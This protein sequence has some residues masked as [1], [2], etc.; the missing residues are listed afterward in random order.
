VSGF[1]GLGARL[2]NACNH[3]GCVR[4]ELSDLLR[5]AAAE[6]WPRPRPVPAPPATRLSLSGCGACACPLRSYF[7]GPAFAPFLRLLLPHFQHKH[8]LCAIW[9][10]Y[11][12]PKGPAHQL[13]PRSTNPSTLARPFLMPGVAK[14]RSPWNLSN[15]PY[16]C[17]LLSFLPGL[18][19]IPEY[20]VRLQGCLVQPAYPGAAEPGAGPSPASAGLLPAPRAPRALGPPCFA[21][22]PWC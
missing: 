21:F 16:R 3:Q 10:R 4:L 8:L 7:P 1:H 12:A 13:R 14:S 20:A 15:E 6:P 5:A 17:H 22:A 19:A 9:R 18:A 11:R 2:S